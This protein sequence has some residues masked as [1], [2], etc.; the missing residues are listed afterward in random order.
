MVVGLTVFCTIG[1]DLLPKIQLDAVRTNLAAARWYGPLQLSPSM[2]ALLVLLFRRRSVLDLWLTVMCWAWVLEMAG[3]SFTTFR[4]SVAW[5]G[6]RMFALACAVTV[7]IV[8]L[9]EATSLYAHLALSV[10]R[11]RQTRALRQVAMDTMAASIAHEIRQPL[12]AM[13]LN[14]EAA[15]AILSAPAPDIEEARFALADVVK[16]LHRTGEVLDGIRQMFKKDFRGRAWLDPNDLIRDVYTLTNVDLRLQQISSVVNL[17]SELPPI[18]A[19]RGQLRQVMMNLIFNA[20]EA[21]RDVTD[22]PRVLRLGSD[23]AQDNSDVVITVEDCGPGVDEKDI[24]RIF[25][26]FFTTKPTG[27]GI[28]L[29]ICRTIVEAHNGRL[30]ASPNVPY[31][32]VFQ[33]FLPIEAA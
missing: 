10:A 16:D 24:G 33:I 4:F 23:V 29:A 32:M 15:T 9:S 5:Y 13:I 12:A 27:T 25:E 7:L 3:N 11:Q 6:S 8:L 2:V 21:M 26:P 30:V 22:R 31:G 14:T 18:L 28:G 1:E 17:R 20:A 19:D